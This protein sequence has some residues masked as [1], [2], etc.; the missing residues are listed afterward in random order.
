MPSDLDWGLSH[1][2]KHACQMG[3]G[4]YFTASERNVVYTETLQFESLLPKYNHK[5]IINNSNGNNNVVLFPSCRNISKVGSLLMLDEVQSVVHE[6]RSPPAGPQ[7]QN[8][9]A[10]GWIPHCSGTDRSL[11]PGVRDSHLIDP[12][13]R[14]LNP[15]CL[16]PRSLHGNDI[17]ELPDGIFSDVAALSHL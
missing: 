11:P 13:P 10:R 3:G 5:H 15:L 6:H 14:R 12:L 16:L 4:G 17:S 2:S 1:H 8:H 7:T 9:Q